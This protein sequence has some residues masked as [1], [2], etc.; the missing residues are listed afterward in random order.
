MKRLALGFLLAL[1]GLP[2]FG[3]Y[4][5]WMVDDSSYC[6][7]ENPSFT[8]AMMRVDGTSQYL[9][10]SYSDASTEW[11]PVL[12]ATDDVPGKAID[13]AWAAIDSV[14]AE[15]PQTRFVLELYASDQ[16][17]PARSSSFTYEM[18][19]DSIVQTIPSQTEQFPAAFGAWSVVPEPTSG[20][21]TLFGVALLALKRKQA[22]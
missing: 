14:Y 7:W 1:A 3:D 9:Q 5:Y 10:L 8:Y 19:K 13:G 2:S 15:D 16:A 11:G 22:I 17:Q 21:L 4:L 12:A 20:L 6:D 18:L